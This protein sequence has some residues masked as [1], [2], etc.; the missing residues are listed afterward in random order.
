MSSVCRSGCPFTPL[1]CT[2]STPTLLHWGTPV[3]TGQDSQLHGIFGRSGKLEELLS[4][5][6]ICNTFNESCVRDSYFPHIGITER[7][8]AEVFFVVSQVRDVFIDRQFSHN[9]TRKPYPQQ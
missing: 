3:L 1:I 7:S 8:G 2:A 4:G 5:T 9:V 6:S